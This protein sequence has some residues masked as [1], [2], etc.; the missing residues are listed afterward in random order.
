MEDS[1]EAEEDVN[2]NMN[3]YASDGVHVHVV[4]GYVSV[5][6]YMKMIHKHSKSITY[7]LEAMWT[8]GIYMVPFALDKRDV[9]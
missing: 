7:G 2:M 6:V 3:R 4:L 5:H 8:I 9:N 1:E